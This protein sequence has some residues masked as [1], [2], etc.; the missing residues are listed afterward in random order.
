MSPP[1]GVSGGNGSDRDEILDIL[2]AQIRQAETQIEALD[3]DPRDFEA[4]R[5]KI[6]WIRTLGYLTGQYRKLSKDTDLDEME[7]DVE[8]L[9][10][11][12]GLED[13]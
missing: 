3:P 2:A 5:L 8:L 12:A 6:K 4:Q 11:I 7:E 13:E 9:Q 1:S 10:T